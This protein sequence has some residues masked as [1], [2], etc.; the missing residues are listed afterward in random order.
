MTDYT[1]KDYLILDEKTKI[2]S[3][4]K[5]YN[6]KR[7]KAFIM[8]IGSKNKF[9]N[10]IFNEFLIKNIDNIYEYQNMNGTNTLN[11][12]SKIEEGEKEHP[13]IINLYNKENYENILNGFL[14]YR[15]YIY[16]KKLKI[17]LLVSDLGF[18]YLED[19]CEDLLILNSFAYNFKSEG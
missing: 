17:F 13:I 11:E 7:N 3:L 12:V 16:D 14:F 18:N 5:T 19:F 9:L 8:T 2:D 1:L 15:D 6:K 10:H 4:I